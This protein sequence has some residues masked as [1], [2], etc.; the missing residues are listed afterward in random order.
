MLMSKQE[1]NHR[2]IENYLFNRSRAFRRA[3]GVGLR[4]LGEGAFGEKG[5][6]SMTATS[7]QHCSK[8]ALKW[9]QHGCQMGPG[10]VPGRP[11]RP[12]GGLLELLKMPGR[13]R[14]GFWG[15]M[16]RYGRP[17]EAHFGFPFES[18]FGSFLGANF[19]TPF[20]VDFLRFGGPF[21][22]RFLRVS[23]HKK[24]LLARRFNMQNQ[25]KTICFS[26]LFEG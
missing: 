15:R 18:L 20:V 2:R 11:W 26:I 23:E 12:L 10:G 24:R 9:S 8:M 3:W 17:L 7:L 21:R 6:T 5:V 19:W 25:W 14:G 13:L 4:A 1:F 22:G 16:G